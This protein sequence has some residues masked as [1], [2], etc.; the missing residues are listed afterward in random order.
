MGCEKT[1]TILLRVWE[2]ANE[3]KKESDLEE[4]MRVEEWKK[5][6]WRKE[7]GKESKRTRVRRRYQNPIGYIL[8]L[9]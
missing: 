9:P 5:E 4:S 2:K 8:R 6:R 3:R 7:E 1:V